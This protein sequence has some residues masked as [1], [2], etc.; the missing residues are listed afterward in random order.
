MP[1][2]LGRSSIDASSL[3][4][5][6]DVAF[7]VGLFVGPH[8]FSVVGMLAKA[9]SWTIATLWQSLLSA[10]PKCIYVLGGYTSDDHRLGSVERLNLSTGAW[11]AVPPLASCRGGAAAATLAGRI[12]VCGGCVEHHVVLSS[13]E[14]FDPVQGAWEAIGP[15]MLARQGASAAVICDTLRICGGW[16]EQD[17]PLDCTEE[18]AGGIV[19]MGP[20]RLGDVCL[21]EPRSWAAAGTVDSQ[22]LICGGQNR[23]DPLNSA[24]CIN[25]AASCVRRLPPMLEKRSA[26]SAAVSHGRLYV[27]GGWDENRQNLRTVECFDPHLEAWEYVAQMVLRRFGAAACSSSGGIYIFGGYEEDDVDACLKSSEHLDV[28]S[29]EWA[30]A[31]PMRVPRSGAVAVSMWA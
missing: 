8:A 26:P 29:V 12:Y 23:N 16:G 10:S 3:L 4:C 28:V 27:A 22:L 21:L 14:R 19:G 2:G 18:L 25:F 5:V 30:L 31:T 7:L 17:A 11:E 20:W 15:M 24:E 13:V 1:C 6:C 9:P